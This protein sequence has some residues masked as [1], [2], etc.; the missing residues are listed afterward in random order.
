VLSL[1]TKQ[2]LIRCLPYLLLCW[3]HQALSQLAFRFDRVATLCD[4]VFALQAKYCLAVTAD[5]DGATISWETETSGG[6]VEV[7]FPGLS[8]MYPDEPVRGHVEAIVGEVRL[9]LRGD[10]DS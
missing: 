1:E 4:E 2:H 9:L 8:W 10:H 7:S 3:F 6:L 5:V